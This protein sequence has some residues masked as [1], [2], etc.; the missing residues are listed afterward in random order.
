MADA[1]GLAAEL[2]GTAPTRASLRRPGGHGEARFPRR[3]AQRA[4][5]H[6][7]HRVRATGRQSA[8]VAHP[9]LPR[10]RPS[11]P[12]DRHDL[13]RGARERQL[14]GRMSNAPR[15]AAVRDPLGPRLSLPLARTDCDSREERPGQVDVEE[16]VQPR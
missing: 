16:G 2:T 5:T 15:W 10:R 1:V 9:R 8:P 3:S 14:E 6:R 13:E 11:R 7:H 4:S 12:V